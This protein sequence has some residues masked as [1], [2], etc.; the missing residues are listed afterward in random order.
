MMSGHLSTAIDRQNKLEDIL[1]DLAQDLG[2]ESDIAKDLQTQISSIMSD[3][4][5][6]SNIGK[7]TANQNQRSKRRICVER[8]DGD[9]IVHED[10]RSLEKK[11]DDLRLE[12]E[13]TEMNGTKSES[14]IS[15][16]TESDRRLSLKI[17]DLEVQSSKEQRVRHVATE[18]APKTVNEQ[19]STGIEVSEFISFHRDQ[20][21]I[22]QK[23]IDLV[24]SWYDENDIT[25]KKENMARFHEMLSRMIKSQETYREQTDSAHRVVLQRGVNE[26]SRL[27]QIIKNLRF[28]GKQ[29]AYLVSQTLCQNQRLQQQVELLERENHVA[30]K[31]VSA[32]ETELKATRIKMY[33]MEK[34]VERSRDRCKL[35]EHSS[36][37]TMH[38]SG[39]HGIDSYH[40]EIGNIHFHA[41]R[42][43][44]EHHIM[45]L[46]SLNSASNQSEHDE[47]TSFFKEPMD[48]PLVQ[49]QQELDILQENMVIIKTTMD[50]NRKRYQHAVQNFRQ[51][52]T[53]TQ[54]DKGQIKGLETVLKQSQHRI[55]LQ[56][57]R[58]NE[59]YVALENSAKET[60]IKVFGIRQQIKEHGKLQEADS[61]MNGKG[62]R[63]C[64]D[65]ADFEIHEE[66]ASLS[67]QHQVTPTDSSNKSDSTISKCISGDCKRASSK[68]REHGV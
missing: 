23:L 26:Q 46:D 34:T 47:S 29:D 12:I 1:N 16:S 38:S 65:S 8:Y 55:N 33:E 61:L 54:M 41:S 35:S 60:S 20:R 32:L 43:C 45:R 42:S 44:D 5:K 30:Q 67:F 31:A 57:E 50:R 24:E 59:E 17:K 21:E 56:I 66:S 9:N 4:T 11:V 53:V 18:Q 36:T 49:L 3:L 28:K 68:D 39:S 25:K 58:L 51:I 64:S 22:K 52:R 6:Q 63:S 62:H 13:S 10:V 2:S 15:R 37:S 19:K 48:S 40:S 7:Q 14:N 27:E